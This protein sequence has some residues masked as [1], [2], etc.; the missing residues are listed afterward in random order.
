MKNDI[1]TYLAQQS[2]AQLVAG[3]VRDS[4]AHAF[5]AKLLARTVVVAAASAVFFLVSPT[6]GFVALAVGIFL[7]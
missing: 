4:L 1:R 6:A 7:L 3:L 2:N 5:V